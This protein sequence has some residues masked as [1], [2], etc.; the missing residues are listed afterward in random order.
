MITGRVATTALAGLLT[1]GAA[2]GPPDRPA[3]RQ[4][5]S[6]T[7]AYEV[8]GLRVIQRVNRGNDLVNVSLYLLGGTRQLT[9][10]T[11]G[12]EELL[13]A[14]SSYGTQSFPEGLA[15]RAMA[16]TGSIEV[17]DPEADWT[18]FGFIGLN[19]HLDSTW[20]VFADRLMH[21]TLSAQAVSR[22][23]DRM[24]AAVRLRFSDPDARIRVIANQVAF[25]GHPYALD[26]EGTSES[27]A[28]LTAEDLAQY[29][30]TQMVTSRMLLVVVGNVERAQVESLV[31]ATI[32]RLPH[33][34][35]KW[36]LP[37]PVPHQ[38]ESHWLIEPRVLPTNYIL[39]Y[40][41][42]PSA[43]AYD[44]AAF[45][46]ATDLLSSQLYRAIR[47]EHSLSYAAYAPF[48]ERAVGVGGMYASTAQPE[49]ALPLMRDQIR[50]MHVQEIS[51]FELH[52][53]I[54]HY[55]LDYLAQSGTDAAQADFLARAELYSG[56]YRQTDRYMQQLRRVAPEDIDHA[57]QRYMRDIQWAYLGDTLRMRGAW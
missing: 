41:T 50:V 40:F 11:A 8:S 33:G 38:K 10:R 55:V 48:L 21:P 42:G 24:L 37:P 30:R 4:A 5:D 44:Y 28:G 43:S 49:R 57:V 35:Y 29:A 23:R 46:V 17:I 20:A 19:Q 32:G 31:T 7:L 26:P 52:R 47:V 3:G 45:R 27:L 54:N 36:T 22:A 15:Q 53:Y 56:D 12:I 18:V 6:L 14:A 1:L 25:A 9:E 2:D 13:L 51:P 16:R 39:G 34:N